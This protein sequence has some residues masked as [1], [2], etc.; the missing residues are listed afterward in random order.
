MRKRSLLRIPVFV[1]LLLAGAHGPAHAQWFL[2][3]PPDSVPLIVAGGSAEVRLAPSRAVVYAAVAGRDTSQVSATAAAIAARERLGTA[4]AQLGLRRD[5]VTLWGAGLG[6]DVPPGPVRMPPG[7]ESESAGAA[8]RFGVR[9]VVDPFAR[10]DAVLGALAR[11]GVESVQFIRLEA[12]DDSAA[13]REA[14]ERAVAQ[15]RLQAEAMAR[16][17]G[18]RL[19]ELRALVTMPSFN[20]ALPDT[21]FFFQG[22]PERGA[23]LAPND[24]SVR[25]V[26]QGAW[27]MRR[28]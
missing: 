24:V 14:T 26:V 17:A 2:D 6:A 9:V 13:V 10:L 15:A 3:P 27:R 28:E 11:S 7:G 12:A 21:R 18:V 19:G 16:A 4:L 22:F 5:A 1:G 20:E 23:P 8:A 25:V